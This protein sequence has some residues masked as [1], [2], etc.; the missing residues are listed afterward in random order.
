MKRTPEEKTQWRNKMRNLCKEVANLPNEKREQLAAQMHVT[1][2]EGRTLSPFNQVFLMF[3]C[4]QPL[5]IVGGFKQWSKAGRI[6]KEGQHAAGYIYVP[7][8]SKKDEAQAVVEDL[9]FLT[10]PVFDISQT[11]EIAI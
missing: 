3:Q 5:T 8:L 4:S 11:Q 1:T 7:M 6:V 9:R 10:V 2:C